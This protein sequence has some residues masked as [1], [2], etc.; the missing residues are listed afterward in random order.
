[1]LIFTGKFGE[2]LNNFYNELYHYTI[3]SYKIVVDSFKD[4]NSD[5]YSKQLS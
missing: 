3:D 4:Q 2:F 1:M 5:F